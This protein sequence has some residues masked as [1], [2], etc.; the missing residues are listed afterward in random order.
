MRILAISDEPSQRLWGELC[1]EAL[2]G[3]DLILSA[4][5]LPSKYLSFLTCF[6]D[7]PIVYVHGNHDDRYEQD[8]PEG[9]KISEPVTVNLVVSRGPNYE[10]TRRPYVIGQSINDLLQTIARTKIVFDITSH[11]ATAQEKPGTVVDQQAIEDEYVPNY[12]RV[13]VEMAMPAD[14]N[15][16]NAY[17]I[18]QEKLPEYPYPVPMK[19]EAY[20]AEGDSYTIVSFSH[21]GGNLTIPYE[22]PRGTTLVLSVADK[23]ESRKVIE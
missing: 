23:V 10:N 11:T 3:V 20:P 18:F 4:G 22:V 14:S 1:R 9:S 13:T 15:D 7:A 6:T 21:P 12:T 5:D 2:S 17:G 19:L 16:D 8:P